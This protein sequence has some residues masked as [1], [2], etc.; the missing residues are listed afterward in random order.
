MT[1]QVKV[2]SIT[3]YSVVCADYFDIP[4]KQSYTLASY[5]A[6]VSIFPE[7]FHIFV[8]RYHR[9]AKCPQLTLYIPIWSPIQ[10]LGW[11]WS[12]DCSPSLVCPDLILPCWITT[13][14]AAFFII[15]FQLF[16]LFCSFQSFCG[17]QSRLSDVN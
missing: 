10:L 11:S 7:V 14:C 5:S 15:M 4:V 17:G 3:A 12:H 6:V 9:L 13:A 1:Y 16:S 2:E 8:L